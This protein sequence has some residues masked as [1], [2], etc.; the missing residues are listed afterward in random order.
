MPKEVSLDYIEYMGWKAILF[1]FLF[2]P[3]LGF[4]GYLL[5]S[6]GIIQSLHLSQFNLSNFLGGTGLIVLAFFALLPL[7]RNRIVKTLVLRLSREK[8]MTLVA[9]ISKNAT[10]SIIILIFGFFLGIFL[11]NAA[12][13][14]FS[15]GI[16]FL[17]LP[18]NLLFTDFISDENLTNICFEA[19]KDTLDDYEERQK[20]F[21]R[22]GKIVENRLEIA[23]IRA[24]SNNFIFH[25]NVEL[26]K[27]N[28]IDEDLKCVH[29]WLAD[30]TPFCYRI[31]RKVYG[32]D[33]LKPFLHRSL[34]DKFSKNQA[35]TNV[36]V[37]IT[38]T[39]GTFIIL[40]AILAIIHPQGIQT[41]VNNYFSVK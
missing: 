23:G 20:W 41:F 17:I 30:E 8:L 35:V 11:N 25:F 33:K 19:L 1:N 37:Q 13:S 34:L 38:A 26:L 9:T 7:F 15:F 32:E 40:I 31:M 39:I 29:M 22:I 12:L 10:L 2:S 21:L 14:L 24:S 28:K 27:G 16:T 18:F 3:F 36:A 5:V 6:A 4:F